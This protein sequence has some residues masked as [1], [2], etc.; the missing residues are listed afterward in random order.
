MKVALF[1]LAT[2]SPCSLSK[3]VRLAGAKDQ[4][5]PRHQGDSQWTLVD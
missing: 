3:Q 5:T 2:N 4:M 1:L